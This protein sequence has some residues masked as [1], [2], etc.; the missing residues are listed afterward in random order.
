[1]EYYYQIKGKKGKDN[2]YSFGNWSFP[3]IFSGK[4]EAKSKPE[5][6]LLIEYEYDKKFPLRVLAKDLES[7]EF[8]LSIQEI[9]EDSHFNRLFEKNNCKI[10]GNTFYII[11]HYN[12]QNTKNCG[13]YCSIKCKEESRQVENQKYNDQNVLN[14]ESKPL[15][16]KITHKV[17]NKCYIG[18]TTQIFTLRWYQHFFQG[19]GTKF[20]TEIKNSKV[21]DWIF[22]VIELIEI[23]ESV[24]R[25]EEINNLI[26]IRESFYINKYDS[27]KNGYNSVNAK[28]D[29]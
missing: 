1:M 7:N 27:I 26:A 2:E 24:T 3:P 4:V 9:K 20:H 10:C 11:D 6:R 12:D 21:T 25:I 16:Y 15:I 13:E 28:A 8:L 18:K 17:T 19:T 29:R 14:G 22:E 23:P 5:A